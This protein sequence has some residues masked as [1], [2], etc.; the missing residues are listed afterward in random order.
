MST[1]LIDD[2]EQRDVE[3]LDLPRSYLQ[4]EIPADK[5]ILLHIRN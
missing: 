3:V 5:Q 2:M 4:N 1:L